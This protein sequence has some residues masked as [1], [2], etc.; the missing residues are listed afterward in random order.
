MKRSSI[1]AYSALFALAFA[2]NDGEPAPEATDDTDAVDLP[3]ETERRLLHES[4]TGS[5]CGPCNEASEFI[6]EVTSA[7]PG[8]HTVIKYHLGGDPYFTREGYRRRIAYNTDGSTGY[9]LPW[10]QLDGVN[11]HHPNDM[12][13]DAVYDFTDVYT[14]DWFDQY[15]TPTSTIELSVNHTID[16]QTVSFD[17]DMLPLAEAYDSSSLVLRAAITEGK[18]TLNVGTNGQ[19][20]FY[21]VMKKMVPD[22]GGTALSDLTRGEAQTFNMSY[23]FNGE[24]ADDTSMREPVDHAVEHTVEEF[25]DLHVVV[26]IQ[27]TKTQEVLQS[28]WT[29]LD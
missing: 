20:E 4:F 8:K 13:G 23:T 3:F 27:D 22:D 24:Y 29:E 25:E 21:H 1:V 9:T 6:K 18:T 17:V 11:G 12:D 7:R 15:Q 2:C 14:T 19:T 5:S 10:L 16:G 28:A 26:W